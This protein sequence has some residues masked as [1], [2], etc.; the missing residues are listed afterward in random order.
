MI[1]ISKFLLI[2]TLIFT[3]CSTEDDGNGDGGGTETDSF[4]RG[5]MLANWADN[6]IIPAFSSFSGSTQ[7]LEDLTV[8]FTNDPT[9]ENL[10]ALRSGFESSYIDFQAVAMFDIGKAEELSYRRFLNTYPLDAAE[11]DNKIA[12]GTYNLELPSSFKEQGFPA[13]D[14]LLYGIGETKAEV[15]T[16]Y[17]SDN[18]R[19]YLLDVAKRINDLTVEVNSSWQG[20]F[21]DDFVNN[22]SSSSTGSVDKFTNKYIMYYETFLR[23]GKIGYPSGIFTGSPSPINVEAYYSADLS[24]TLYLEAINNM[25]DFFN[26]KSFNGNQTGKSYKQYLEYLDRGELAS[27]I[28]DQFAAIKSQASNLNSNLKSQVE[29]DNTVM[30][31][32]YDELQKAVV[33]LKLDMVQALSISINYVDS[34]G[35]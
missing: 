4:D 6:I 19:N 20:D 9:E 24:K 25:V 8:A 17:S 32:A 7:Q 31:A 3:A 15:V 34:D 30:L 16:K 21:R 10:T 26:G 23:T 5:A 13:M 2:A 14:Y 1:R 22:T 29:T 33:L 27:D 35:D 28:L 12:S 18:Y 11:V